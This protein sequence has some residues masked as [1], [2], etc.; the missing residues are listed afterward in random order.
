MIFGI[1]GMDRERFRRLCKICFGLSI[2][3][4]LVVGF[5]V[6]FLFANRSPALDYGSVGDMYLEAG[7]RRV[8][9]VH[10]SDTV[11]LVFSR[12]TWLRLCRSDFNASIRIDSRRFDLPPH[13]IVPPRSGGLISP[14]K[15]REI[16][17]P[18]FGAGIAGDAE[19]WADVNSYCWPTDYL[20]PIRTETPRI[21]FRIEEP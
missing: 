16:R 13:R 20:W 2:V 9:V 1:F 7:G 6:L 11:N 10:S 3:T 12:T 18:M 19:L 17:M 15:S 8:E 5:V 21:R 14:P 4:T